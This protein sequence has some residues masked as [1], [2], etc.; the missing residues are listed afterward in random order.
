[1]WPFAS[2]LSLLYWFAKESKASFSSSELFWAL[3]GWCCCSPL[4]PSCKCN[5]VSALPRKGRKLRV[6]QIC[7]GCFQLAELFC[8]GTI[9][10]QRN[11]NREG[12]WSNNW[13]PEGVCIPWKMFASVCWNFVEGSI[14]GR[15]Q[16]TGDAVQWSE[17]FQQPGFVLLLF[18][19]RLSFFSKLRDDREVLL[20]SQRALFFLV[21]TVVPFLYRFFWARYIG[22][23]LSICWEDFWTWGPGQLAWCVCVAWCLVKVNYR[24]SV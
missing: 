20:C 10:L 19:F 8:T 11:I 23:E 7:S 13:E 24:P 22:S 16:P 17:S 6:F 3:A 2:P 9:A 12:N 1:M 18:P 15:E 14:A 5:P 21:I 4:S